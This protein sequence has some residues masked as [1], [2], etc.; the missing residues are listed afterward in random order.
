[1]EIRDANHLIWIIFFPA[2]FSSCFCFES[3]NAWHE[4]SL[5]EAD[6]PWDYVRFYGFT[7][8]WNSQTYP[9]FGMTHE[10]S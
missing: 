10:I 1:M 7:N 5:H 4:S 9:S 8:A 2:L 6:K 3:Q